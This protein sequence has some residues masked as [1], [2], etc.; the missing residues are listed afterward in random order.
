MKTIIIIFMKTKKKFIFKT[1]ANQYFVFFI[2]YKTSTVQSVL[3][4]DNIH[5]FKKMY[6]NA[7]K[8]P[9]HECRGKVMPL[10]YVQMIFCTFLD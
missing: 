5:R 9:C 7:L 3:Q 1:E 6:L 8:R 4:Y 10:G 2:L